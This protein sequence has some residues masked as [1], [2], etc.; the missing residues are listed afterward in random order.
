MKEE[1]TFQLSEQYTDDEVGSALMR[2]RIGRA[3]SLEHAAFRF[4]TSTK[5]ISKYENA[6]GSISDQTITSLL[7]IYNCPYELFI[8]KLEQGTS[9][10]GY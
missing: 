5:Q 10:L 1:Q 2:T 4:G 7:L 3:I 8:E 9:N 6:V